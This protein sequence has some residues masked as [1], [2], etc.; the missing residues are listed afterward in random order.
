MRCPLNVNWIECE[1]LEPNCDDCPIY[2]AT[3]K[4]RF[5]DDTSQRTKP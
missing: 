4:R 2:K 1:A 5:G 3:I